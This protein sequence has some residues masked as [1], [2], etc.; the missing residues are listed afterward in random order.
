MVT[1]KANFYKLTGTILLSSSMMHK[2]QTKSILII[3]ALLPSFFSLGSLNNDIGHA[4][5]TTSLGQSIQQFQNELQSTINEEVQENADNN[6]NNNNNNCSNNFS[7]Q[8]QTNNNGQTTSTN[9]NSCSNT[10]TS[11]SSSSSVSS[12]AAKDLRGAIVSAEYDLQNGSIVNSIFGNWSLSAQVNS[13]INFVA[14]FTKQPV[15]YDQEDSFIPS[16]SSNSNTNINNEITD[17][18]TAATTISPPTPTT[19]QTT[20]LANNSNTLSNTQ[21][22]ITPST[23]NRPINPAAS[24]PSAGPLANATTSTLNSLS[25]SPPTQPSTTESQNRNTEDSAITTSANTTSYSLSNFRANSIS[26][27]NLDIT[28]QGKIDVVRETQSGE[29]NIPD[30]TDTFKDVNAAVSVLGDR[31]LVISF[32]RQSPLFNEF[33]DIPLVGLV[34]Q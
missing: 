18:N 8:T 32:D 13:P 3:L 34:Q 19:N 21:N 22:T 17:T 30:E 14:S 7:V 27:Q 9:R 16:A 12:S 20:N 23:A 6:N 15:S 10:S 28:Y 31:I 11:S 33:R 29:N 5:A 4:N 26:Q 1:E 2:N 24:A 25:P